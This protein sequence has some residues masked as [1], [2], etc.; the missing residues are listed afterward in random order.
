MIATYNQHRM[1]TT[2]LFKAGRITE[3]LEAAE[4]AAKAI[5]EYTPEFIVD[6][7]WRN[8]EVEIADAIVAYLR[9]LARDSRTEGIDR[10]IEPELMLAT[11]EVFEGE[12]YNNAEV[13]WDYG[14]PYFWLWISVLQP[15][16]NNVVNGR[17]ISFEGSLNNH[18]LSAHSLICDACLCEIVRENGDWFEN[19]ERKLTLGEA[20]LLEDLI[21]EWS[22]GLE[23]EM[24]DEPLSSLRYDNDGFRVI[25]CNEY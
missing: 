11:T 4:Q 24:M 5:A 9:E 25:E 20:A 6:N 13:E 14:E 19:G 2:S 10:P 7:P 1:N 18:D 17:Y 16:D 22:F 15:S 21:R 3:A 12:G 8:R 23:N